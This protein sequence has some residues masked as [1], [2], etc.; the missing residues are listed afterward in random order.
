MPRSQPRALGIILY[1]PPSQL[2][3][4]LQ[5]PHKLSLR[6]RVNSLH[7]ATTMSQSRA[8]R[9]PMGIYFAAQDQ[10]VDAEW[11]WAIACRA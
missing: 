11:T 9:E 1:L 2:C 4:W 5:G 6:G 7:L 3:I 8:S 10:V